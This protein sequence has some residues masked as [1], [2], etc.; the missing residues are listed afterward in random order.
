MEKIKLITDAIAFIK[1]VFFRER[2]F[3]RALDIQADQNL[4]NRNS[5]YFEEG[6]EVDFFIRRSRSEFGYALRPGQYK[7]IVNFKKK[8][9][10]TRWEISAALKTSLLKFNGKRPTPALQSH[11][12]GMGMLIAGILA[13]IAAVLWYSYCKYTLLSSIEETFYPSTV[14]SLIQMVFVALLFYLFWT[15]LRYYVEGFVIRAEFRKRKIL[16]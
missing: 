16:K 14:Y 7:A 2:A 15:V 9:Q 8:H 3:Q 1:R 10:L 11:G 6:H 4:A 13:T 12:L 5:R